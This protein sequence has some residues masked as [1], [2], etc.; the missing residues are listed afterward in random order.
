[1]IA[2]FRP[3]FFP[4]KEV[5]NQIPTQS[6]LSTRVALSN[7]PIASEGFAVY[8]GMTQ[9]AFEKHFGQPRE[10]MTAFLGYKWAIYGDTPKHYFQVAYRG[11]KV[12]SIFVL[13]SETEIEP[14]SLGEGIS[15][16]ADVV[17]IYSNLFFDYQGE[18]YG[19]ELTEFEMKYS[20][21]VA[22]ENN[23][24]AILY[25]D[26]ENVDL[27]AIRYLDT[28]MLLELMP[29]QLTAGNPIDFYQE[30]AT[31]WNQLN[32]DNTKQFKEI[33]SIV[34]QQE[35]LPKYQMN[36]QLNTLSH[37]LLDVFLTNPAEL[38]SGED[39]EMWEDGQNQ[40]FFNQKF[41]LD[42]KAMAP[43][44]KANNKVNIST[45]GIIYAPAYDIPSA[46]LSLYYEPSF[47]K[48]FHKE[49]YTDMGI[50]FDKGTLLFMSANPDKLKLETTETSEK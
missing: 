13:G 3:V 5:V 37:W 40:L 46:F 15:E 41:Y 42:N 35:E 43:F 34:R 18:G 27:M 23:S 10:E 14:F 24:F 28:Q 45:S 32:V 12:S 11:D 39:L 6:R 21:L 26:Q 47:Y 49:K 31:D 29:Y 1:M 30:D 38:L 8:I 36:V 20:P 4:K 17:P 25:M 33:L 50:S 22:F 7:D 19:V 44:I 9:E 2:Y 48:L 16:I